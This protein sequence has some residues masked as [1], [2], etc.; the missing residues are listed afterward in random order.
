MGSVASWLWVF[1]VGLP[2]MTP[3]A[4]AQGRVPRG[5]ELLEV[6]DLGGEPERPALAGGI[7][8]T[9]PLILGVEP[10]QD[11]TFLFRLGWLA[12]DQAVSGP[13]PGEPGLASAL[14]DAPDSQAT[15]S[16][17]PPGAPAEI[18]P[19]GGLPLAHTGVPLAP[20]LPE[21][22]PFPPLPPGVLDV[23]IGGNGPHVLVAWAATE[24]PA[25][26][27]SIRLAARRIGPDGRPVGEDL[28]LQVGPG[29]PADLAVAVA[30]EGG[31][32]VAWTNHLPGR[33]AGLRWRAIG[34]KGTLGPLRSDWDIASDQGSPSIA[35]TPT[36]FALASLRTTLS[37]ESAAGDRPFSGARGAE[38]GEGTERVPG[39]ALPDREVLL[40]RLTPTG[41]A[42]R[43]EPIVVA[44]RKGLNHPAMAA[45]GGALWVFWT[46]PRGGGRM[47]RTRAYTADGSPLGPE[48]MLRTDLRLAGENPYRVAPAGDGYW[49]VAW[50]QL[51]GRGL[52]MVLEA[53]LFHSTGN[54]AGPPLLVARSLGSIA[55]RDLVASHTADRWIALWTEEEAGQ[56]RLRYRPLR[57]E[58]G[59]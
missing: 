50:P 24:G 59:P 39:P 57:R 33:G 45:R 38:E 1:A 55:L 21:V 13:L 52:S 16:E 14:P 48:G 30:P 34:E 37:G 6:G 32:V 19:A 51:E 43:G 56:H 18:L 8:A 25:S 23:A 28:T 54:A 2:A 44:A 22:L 42:V 58:F 46:D 41:G 29:R 36:G 26:A 5:I 9:D 49:L 4:L 40:R 17:R 10:G 27:P 47:L 35:V 3:I 15:R 11:R 20:S 7:W 53:R 12:A 31:A